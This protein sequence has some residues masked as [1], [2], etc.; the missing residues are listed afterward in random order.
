MTGIAWPSCSGPIPAWAWFS[1]FR[2]LAVEPGTGVDGKV[3][4]SAGRDAQD[5]G[6][7]LQS[8]PHDEPQLDQ[9]A[10]EFPAI[11]SK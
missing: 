9:S 10:N 6:C 4:G 5:L 3:P 2:H 1:S 7:L 8:H 11:L